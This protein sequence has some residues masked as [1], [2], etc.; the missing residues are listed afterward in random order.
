MT[1]RARLV[2]NELREPAAGE[3]RIRVLAA[4]VSRPDVSVRRGE[5]LYS[6]TPLGQKVPFVPGYAVVGDVDAVGEGVTEAEVGD[7]LVSYGE[8]P[9]FG[10]LARVVAVNLLPNGKS[11]KLYGTS[12]YGDGQPGAGDGGPGSGGSRR[13]GLIQGRGVGGE[14][15]DVV[16]V[17]GDAP[18]V[19][20]RVGEVEGGGDVEG[21]GPE[22]VAHGKEGL[23]ALFV[24]GPGIGF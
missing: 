19:V 20:A 2:A 17:G 1:R 3:M 6:G 23:P 22:E 7:R 9:G 15:V 10:E 5:S 4:A 21:G 12:L 16:E 11:F 18:V 24:A 8:P 13:P 14:G